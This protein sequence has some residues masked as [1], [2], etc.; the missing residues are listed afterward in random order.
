M[1]EDL[2]FIGLRAIYG[3]QV[4]VSDGRKIL[5]HNRLRVRE[6][7]SPATTAT[8]RA[9]SSQVTSPEIGVS[10]KDNLCLEDQQTMPLLK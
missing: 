3:Q 5:L 6:L 2:N 7:H 1:A 8:S 4:G 10:F 9:T